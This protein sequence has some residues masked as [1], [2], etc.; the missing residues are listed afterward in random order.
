MPKDAIEDG[1]AQAGTGAL[2]DPS[3]Y[4]RI[5]QLQYLNSRYIRGDN[6]PEYARFLGYLDAKDLYPELKG[7]TLEAYCQDVLNGTARGVYETRRAAA[8]AASQKSDTA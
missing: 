6:S 3:S 1:I 2:S 4:A 7:N 8:A 5:S